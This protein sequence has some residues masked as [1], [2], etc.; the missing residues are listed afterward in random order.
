M[1]RSFAVAWPLSHS[2]FEHF[3]LYWI[4]DSPY[5]AGKERMQTVHQSFLLSF[6]SPCFQAPLGFVFQ[7]LV[8]DHFNLSF[9]TSL[10]P[11]T[12]QLI[13]FAMP[14]PALQSGLLVMFAAST[15]HQN[16]W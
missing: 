14:A 9:I 8:V 7:D 2:A 4:S 5:L 13:L 11:L 3:S 10:A 16:S 12:S 15:T 1:Q 6:I